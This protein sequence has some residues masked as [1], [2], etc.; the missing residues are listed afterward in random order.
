MKSVGFF[1]WTGPLPSQAML[2]AALSGARRAQV[3]RGGMVCD[4]PLGRD[5]LLD[6]EDE[7]SVAALVRALQIVEGSAGRCDLC[8]GDPTIV[9]LTGDG[10]RV[11]LAVHHGNCIRWDAWSDDAKLASGESLLAWLAEQGITYPRDEEREALRRREADAQAARHWLAGMPSCFERFSARVFEEQLAADP[12]ALMAPLQ[13]A[14][15]DARDQALALFEWLGHG[16]GSWTGFPV[17]ECV[18]ERLLLCMPMSALTGALR[19]DLSEAQLEGAARFFAGWQFRNGRLSDAARLGR[20]D[21]SKLLTHVLSS[22]DADKQQ[23]AQK[24]FAQANQPSRTT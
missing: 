7:K 8:L 4:Q 23:R 1:A 21:R 20:S 16:V 6:T 9:L 24:A 10:R 12:S 3:I 18:P 22:S 19:Q 15:P 17:Y 11:T 14:L 2:S 13:A 5:V